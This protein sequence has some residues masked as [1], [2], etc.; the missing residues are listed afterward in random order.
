MLLFHHMNSIAFSSSSSVIVQGSY[1]GAFSLT[2]CNV[3]SVCWP[4]FSLVRVSVISISITYLLP[5]GL[6][7]LQFVFLSQHLRQKFLFDRLA[8]L[9]ILPVT[10]T[11]KVV[12][13]YTKW[14]DDVNKMLWRLTQLF[15]YSFIAIFNVQ[16]NCY[17]I[18]TVTCT[19]NIVTMSSKWRDDVHKM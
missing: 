15:S 8:F 3:P 9:L 7:S 13:M 18:L 4:V 12:T 6:F 19:K 14:C 5:A 17:L 2:F 10:Y 16:L 1:A 11:Q